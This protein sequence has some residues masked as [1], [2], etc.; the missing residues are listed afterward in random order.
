MESVAWAL[1]GLNGCLIVAAVHKERHVNQYIN[2]DDPFYLSLKFLL[3]RLYMHWAKELANGQRLLCVFEQRGRNEDRRTTAWFDEICGGDNHL[4]KPFPF[5]IDFRPKD[6]NVIGHQY[7]DLVAYA[8]CRFVETGDETRTD[9]QAV[10]GKLRRFR[11]K[12][13]GHGLKVFP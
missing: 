3:E 11:G 10:K 4:R 1:D 7:A 2:P 13:E 12:Y 8:A 5:D 6:Q 9:W